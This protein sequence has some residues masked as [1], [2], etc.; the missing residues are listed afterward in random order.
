MSIFLNIFSFGYM[1]KFTIYLVRLS[2][3]NSYFT[4]GLF[5]RAFH[6]IVVDAVDICG[7]KQYKSEFLVYRNVGFVVRFK[8]NRQI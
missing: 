5:C 6:K 8:T 7:G 4:F 1:T 3:L 2:I